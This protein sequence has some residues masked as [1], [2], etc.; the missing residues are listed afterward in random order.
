MQAMIIIKGKF[1]DA[2]ELEK[3]ID[4]KEYLELAGRMVWAC[5][6][7]DSL[8]LCRTTGW[9]HPLTR[10]PDN[11][12]RV[13]QWRLGESAWFSMSDE[14]KGLATGDIRK[15]TDTEYYWSASNG[16]I[17]SCGTT[18]GIYII[19]S[20][21]APKPKSADELVAAFVEVWRIRGEHAFGEA[22]DALCTEAK[23]QFLAATA[24]EE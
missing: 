14:A 17:Q 10:L 11:D 5:D 8:H 12:P 13:V 1:Y 6:K 2:G 4:G 18:A 24:D 20:P 19:L 22:M 15:V 16:I 3:V 9:R 23:E 21:P 7:D